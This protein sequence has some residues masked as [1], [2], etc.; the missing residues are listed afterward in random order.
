ME[1][2]S[3][4]FRLLQLL[5]F[6]HVA[7]KLIFC[8]ISLAL[9]I[10]PL[11]VSSSIYS[12]STSCVSYSIAT[13]INSPSAFIP[14]LRGHTYTHIYIYIYI[15]HFCFHTCSRIPPPLLIVLMSEVEEQ[16]PPGV[17]EV[18]VEEVAAESPV[19]LDIGQDEVEDVIPVIAEE[20]DGAGGDTNEQNPAEDHND[21]AAPVHE[22]E[23]APAAEGAAEDEGQMEA[24]QEEPAA[25]NAD[26]DEPASAAGSPQHP[27]GAPPP[28]APRT[29]N[30]LSKTENVSLEGGRVSTASHAGVIDILG[31]PTSG[32]MPSISSSIPQKQQEHKAADPQQW[33][34]AK[35][36]GRPHSH[37]SKAHATSNGDAAADAS[38]ANPQ[39]SSGSTQHGAASEVGH[40]KKA[41]TDVGGRSA[42]SA[43]QTSRRSSRG[44]SASQGRD[45]IRR[46]VEAVNSGEGGMTTGP[47]FNA[48][49]AT[50]LEEYTRF[51]RHYKVS[52]SYRGPIY[53]AEDVMVPC[54]A[55]GGPLDPISRVPV[56]RLFFHPN[57]VECFLCGLKSL[58][59][60]YF[61][62]G[63][64]AVCSNCAEKGY[65]LCVPKEEAKQRGMILGSIRGNAY[66][67]FRRTDMARRRSAR[68]VLN[69]PTVPGVS[70]PSLSIGG[71]HNRRNTTRRT[72]ELL[73]RQQHY[74][75][76]DCNI[77]FKPIQDSPA[78]PTGQQKRIAE[79]HSVEL[80]KLKERGAPLFKYN[81]FFLCGS[82]CLPIGCTGIQKR[83]LRNRREETRKC[84]LEEEW[85]C[86]LP[87]NTFTLP[88]ALEHVK[89]Y[90][91]FFFLIFIIDAL[92]WEPRTPHRCYRCSPTE[93]C[94]R[95]HYWVPNDRAEEIQRLHNNKNQN[96]AGTD[97]WMVQCSIPLEQLE[98]PYRLIMKPLDYGYVSFPHF[99]S[100]FFFVIVTLVNH[101]QSSTNS[102]QNNNNKIRVLLSPGTFHT[103]RE[104]LLVRLHPAHGRSSPTRRR[105][106]LS[107][108]ELRYDRQ[109]R[110]WG[111][112]GQAAL[113]RS[114]VVVLGATGAAV[115]AAKNLLLSGVGEVTLVDHH[116]VS[117]AHLAQH[118][119]LPMNSVGLPVAPVLAAE[120][121]L[122]NPSSTVRGVEQDVE[123]WA[124]SWKESLRGQR[125][126]A[127][128]RSVYS[129]VLV[130]SAYR[131]WSPLSPLML[132]AAWLKVPCV[133]V[134]AQGLIG[135]WIEAHPPPDTWLPLSTLTDDTARVQDLRPLAPFPSLREWFQRHT[136]PA[137]APDESD[138]D[139]K[140]R[141]DTAQGGRL[142]YLLVLHWAYERWRTERGEPLPRS[143]PSLSPETYKALRSE[144]L[145][146]LREE[147]SGLT[148]ACAMEALSKCTPALNRACCDPDHLPS[149]LRELLEHPA[150]VTPSIA[151]CGGS[152]PRSGPPPPPSTP[153]GS[154]GAAPTHVWA[155]EGKEVETPAEHICQGDTIPHHAWLEQY[156]RRAVIDRTEDGGVAPSH[157]SSPA[158]GPLVAYQR[159]VL[160]WYVVH[161]LRCYYLE[162]GRESGCGGT[163]AHYALPFNGFF[164]DMES[165]TAFYVELRA[166]YHEEHERDVFWV[167]HRA[168]NQLSADLMEMSGATRTERR[169]Q[170]EEETGTS[171]ALPPPPFLFRP[172][173]LPR[174]DE[175]LLGFFAGLTDDTV[176]RD[177]DESYAA[178][179]D[180]VKGE[181]MHIARDLISS[182]WTA[183]AARFLHSH[184]ALLF[185]CS[186]KCTTDQPPA[187]E[188][189]VRW[190]ALH[191]ARVGRLVHLSYEMWEALQTGAHDDEME[192]SA[193]GLDALFAAV[194]CIIQEERR[195]CTA[196]AAHGSAVLDP[197]ATVVSEMAAAVSREI[198]GGRLDCTT[199]DEEHSGSLVA[200][201][202]AE[203]HDS[204]PGEDGVRRPL[205]S[206]GFEAYCRQI[207]T[208]VCRQVGNEAEVVSVAAACGS[209]AAQESVKLLQHR[210]TPATCSIF[211]SA[212]ANTIQ[213]E[214]IYNEEDIHIPFPFPN[215]VSYRGT[216]R[217]HTLRPCFAPGRP[218]RCLLGTAAAS[219][220]P[221]SSLIDTW[222]GSGIVAAY[223]PCGLPCFPAEHVAQC[224]TGAALF[225]SSC[226]AAVP[227]T[228]TSASDAAEKGHS[229]SLLARVAA[230]YPPAAG[231]LGP[232]PV[233][234]V[235][236]LA[237][238]PALLRGASARRA[239][240]CSALEKGVAL[241]AWRQE[242]AEV[243]RQAARLGLVRVQYH[244]V[245]R[246]PS[247]VAA[248]LH[249]VMRRGRDDAA[250]ENP[251]ATGASGLSELPLAARLN[252]YIAH[253]VER[254]RGLVRPAATSPDEDGVA[255]GPV[256]QT[257][258]RETV[259]ASPLVAGQHLV[260]TS[261]H[262]LRR[263]GTLTACLRRADEPVPPEWA[264]AAAQ[265][266]RL[267]A[268]FLDPLG[269]T[270]GD[271]GGA[272]CCTAE[273]RAGSDAAPHPW[274][275]LQDRLALTADRRY[276][277]RGAVSRSAA[278]AAPASRA[279]SLS[280]R[281]VAVTPPARDREEGDGHSSATALYEVEGG[282]TLTADEVRAVF[283]AEGFTVVNDYV[284]DVALAEAMQAVQ[285]AVQR[286]SPQRR[287]EV[288]GLKDLP[289][290]AE[291]WLRSGASPEELVYLPLAT[292][293][294][295]MID[296]WWSIAT[297]TAPQEAA[298]VPAW[299]QQLQCSPTS[300]RDMARR[301]VLHVLAT[302]PALRQPS[303]SGSPGAAHADGGYVC[304]AAAVLPLLLGSGVEAIGFRFPDPGR[305]PNLLA[306]QHAATSL[307]LQ[308]QRGGAASA[309]LPP[310]PLLSSLK[311]TLVFHRI[312][313]GSSEEPT[314]EEVI[315]ANGVPHGSCALDPGPCGLHTFTDRHAMRDALSPP[316]ASLRPAERE[317]AAV[318]VAGGKEGERLP[319][320]D[321]PV[322]AAPSPVWCSSA[323]AAMLLPVQQKEGPRNGRAAWLEGLA[324]SW[325]AVA[326]RVRVPGWL[327]P[328]FHH[329]IPHTHRTQQ[330]QQEGEGEGIQMEQPGGGGGGVRV[331]EERAPAGLPVFVRAEDGPSAMHCRRCGTLHGPATRHVAPHTWEDCPLLDISPHPSAGAVS[332]LPAGGAAE[333]LLLDTTAAPLSSV[334]AVRDAISAPVPTGARGP[335]ANALVRV[336]TAQLERRTAAPEDIRRAA[337][338]N[339]KR[340]PMQRRSLRCAYCHGRHHV[341]ECPR[342]EGSA[343]NGGAAGA[344]VVPPSAGVL[345]ADSY[346]SSLKGNA[347]R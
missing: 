66:D 60:P 205:V 306:L 158:L 339:R 28:Q 244:V 190:R 133:F 169:E 207:A 206:P 55:C 69:Q 220:A 311:E 64:R 180:L 105:R 257:F 290:R 263:H 288:L 77:L 68:D 15:L 6:D 134:E 225:T 221:S 275:P 121:A 286:L 277:R 232:P 8:L 226:T 97:L 309:S 267:D 166:I 72:F 151:L 23:E 44:G 59:E 292:Y 294:Q 38:Q 56:G 125:P 178:A 330:Q 215:Y 174:G 171:Q 63:D 122:L 26:I 284:H 282:G 150:A 18:P 90:I 295:E 181:L 168:L 153:R 316:P 210:R 85:E 75:Q 33:S 336:S 255:L 258:G 196:P 302:D 29:S 91:V 193:R 36:G 88:Y 202:A 344:A 172:F 148:Q 261:R 157:S 197:L 76:N 307:L 300:L 101:K 49:L 164:P 139:L 274:I 112:D 25:E 317:T 113:Q 87:S 79:S 260:D 110:L 83:M 283:H 328:L 170:A 109:L 327:D 182:V 217:M 183:H 266:Q 162:G 21:A 65:A 204:A 324:Q 124:Q 5:L 16:L 213:Q 203:P 114:H 58:T 152:V 315:G 248:R 62:V 237:A 231:A 245:C 331:F 173:Q 291:H 116:T 96:K 270:K 48:A 128:H 312:A 159:G 12:P 9:P 103:P 194:L 303:P 119:F 32:Q 118:F 108:R 308:Q 140:R 3:F 100:I 252:P 39:P 216:S 104:N 17:E 313:C 89:D 314:G 299:R 251:A 224:E 123:A 54:V 332:T 175:T 70:A 98:G 269:T 42:G 111:E 200:S 253:H 14:A 345:L 43:H 13:F 22:E 240:R 343:V 20:G 102:T 195:R 320:P 71:L 337:A 52:P 187:L 61:Q 47:Q 40:K 323:L 338:A 297:S 278:V 51:R 279:V 147:R 154:T 115:A 167:A 1:H 304:P 37:K 249:A 19:A 256:Q 78:P 57:C 31:T 218:L 156:Y 334:A 130:S 276:V 235:L 107:E 239:N 27:D 93:P 236:P 99:Y 198:G 329:S 138:V 127:L 176:K 212:Y 160:Q 199:K 246:L 106:N 310:S 296:T 2:A 41:S 67:T 117:P 247:S 30:S 120:L 144:I 142:P 177:T 241:L 201:S 189:A 264:A 7:W 233:S 129:L 318:S 285:R 281:L 341:A 141:S 135:G 227:P 74:T 188:V 273:H 305:R 262:L 143:T 259:S 92:W 81:S 265:Q 132:A 322:P 268:L 219:P 208:E 149:P 126:S 192:I 136:P 24:T 228:S 4:G 335:A 84:T 45:R 223:K 185:P 186:K 301:L 10:Q 347:K 254:H 82:S 287:A 342:L 131:D 11:R 333:R 325:A 326:Q 234:L 46:S 34:A 165:S 184:H 86:L 272:R 211:Y 222:Y 145:K 155:M 209:L 94:S 340:P 214:D 146:M 346:I 243:L 298:E 161:A 289:L 242:E 321:S 53:V 73:Q 293:S 191:D 230:A 250:E 271:G 50:P 95:T 80:P 229:D 280:F 35:D 137:S 163:A 179:L 319:L 238:S